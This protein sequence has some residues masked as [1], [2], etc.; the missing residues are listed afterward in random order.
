MRKPKPGEIWKAKA[1]LLLY[2]VGKEKE[3]IV[4]WLNTNNITHKGVPMQSALPVGSFRDA[5]YVCTP[6]WD[7]LETKILKEI[8]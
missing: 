5:E 6:D 8:T 7:D 2:S 4:L 1:G 3:L